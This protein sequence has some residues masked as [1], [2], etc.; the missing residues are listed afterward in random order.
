MTAVLRVDLCEAEHLRVGQATAQVLL[1]LFEIGHLLG[2]EGKT[3]LL[4]ILGQIVDVYNRSRLNVDEE[5][6][7]VQSLV[8]ALQ[9]GVILGL[10]A[11]HG[12][13]LLD[14]CDALD[15]HVLGNLHGIGTPR[16]DHLAARTD[17]VALHGFA[18]YQF[19]IAEQPTQFLD[20][21]LAGL[22][23]GLRSNDVSGL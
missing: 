12:V 3:L 16:G 20:S 7:L 21:F 4:V 9:H 17:E 6:L 18:L 8:H 10:L 2:R 14:T 1:H 5:E 23:Y 11:C 13:V 15:T 22:L 19:G